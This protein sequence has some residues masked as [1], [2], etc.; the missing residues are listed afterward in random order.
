M[1]STKRRSGFTLVELLISIV[2][3]ALLLAIGGPSF[4][5][6]LHNVRLRNMSEAIQNGIH[7][8]R[9][10][11]VRRN[12]Q[13]RFQLVNTLDNGC[14]LTTAGPNWI[15]SMDSAAGACG[16]TNM[17]DAAAAVAPRVIQSRSASDG[18]ASVV[19]AADQSTIVFNGLG[20]VTNV[21]SAS[22]DITN[23]SGGACA[24]S[25]G[26]MR[27]LRVTVSAGGQV[28]MCDPRFVSAT[29]SE[30]C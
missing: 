2:L 26:P 8:A 21:P 3:L 4:S 6:W 25:S 16:S 28:R 11:A 23:P 1:L 13:V 20:R 10:E 5:Q 22:I 9:A 27:C 29:N 7:L 19:V 24:A 12:A 30:G 14:A 15:V 17:A 18:S